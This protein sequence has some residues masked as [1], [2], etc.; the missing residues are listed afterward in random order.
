[1]VHTGLYIQ[2]GADPQ[3]LISRFAN[4]EINKTISKDHVFQTNN[5]LESI[6]RYPTTLNKMSSDD[7]E[8]ISRNG[9]EVAMAN[10]L[11]QSKDT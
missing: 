4:D 1:M 9:F 8:K 10:A 6:K 5:E 2:L 3:N 11:I 7:F